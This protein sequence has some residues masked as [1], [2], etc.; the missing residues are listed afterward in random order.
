MHVFIGGTASGKRQRVAER[1]PEARWRDADEM[2]R[3][4]PG[5]GVGPSPGAGAGPAIDDGDTVVISG[6]LAWL[7]AELEN[8]RENESASAD[9]DR[10]GRR[11]R[12][13]FAGWAS[14]PGRRVLVLEEVGRGIVPVDPAQRRLRDL[15]GWLSQDAV[16]LA[17]QAHYVRHGLTMRLD[18]KEAAA[19]GRAD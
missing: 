15:M 11:W 13:V 2:M 5:A 3:R 7:E 19:A 17:S 10:L 1:Y 18:G 8:E 12:E 16:R 9:D 4:V 6:W 14:S